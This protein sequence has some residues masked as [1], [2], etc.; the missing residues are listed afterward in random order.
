MAL[1]FKPMRSMIFTDL[2]KEQ[3]RGYIAKRQEED[4]IWQMYTLQKI[5]S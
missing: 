3:Y 2:A 5:H 4:Q 1:E